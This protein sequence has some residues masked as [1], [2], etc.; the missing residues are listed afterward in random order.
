VCN[1]G[2]EESIKKVKRL[3]EKSLYF[4]NAIAKRTS[5]KGSHLLPKA[6]MAWVNRVMARKIRKV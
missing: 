4:L 2:R 1:G 6:E 3:L 5:N